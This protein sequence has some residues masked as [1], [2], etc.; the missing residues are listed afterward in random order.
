MLHAA[1]LIA[2]LL[3]AQEPARP[4]EVRVPVSETGEID[5]AEV[6]A[7]LAERA[8]VEGEKPRGSLR[9][10]IAG[11]AGALT[12]RLLNEPLGPDVTIKLTPAELVVRVDPDALEPARLPRFRERL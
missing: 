4:V 12:R 9:L 2:L 3:T 11:L 5:A 8:A 6:V 7:R 10:S 1:C